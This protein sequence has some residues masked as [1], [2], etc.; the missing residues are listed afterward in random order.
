MIYFALHVKGNSNTCLSICIF[1]WKECSLSWLY[2]SWIYNYLCNQ[3]LWPRKVRVWTP[4][5]ARSLDIT[6]CD[7]VCLW[8][9]IC[10]WFSPGIPVCSMN[11]NDRHYATEIL[12]KVALNT[13]NL[14]SDRLQCPQGNVQNTSLNA[15][16]WIWS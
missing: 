2:C 1:L 16:I 13:I 11:K 5:M 9:A 14:N 12:L 8:L 6:L 3:C 4:F 7:K 15:V 10:R